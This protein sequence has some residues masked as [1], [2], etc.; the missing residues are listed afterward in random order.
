MQEG[1]RKFTP[2][3]RDEAVRMVIEAAR[4]IAETPR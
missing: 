3:F 4:P 2:E 1:R